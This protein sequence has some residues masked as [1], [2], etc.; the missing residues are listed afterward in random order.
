MKHIALV[1]GLMLLSFA[2]PVSAQTLTD[3]QKADIEKAVK[4]QVAQYFRTVDTM[5]VDAALK[6]WSRE[7]LIAQVASGRVVPSI[8]TMTTNWKNA[9]ANRKTHHFEIQDVMVRV[10][11][12]DTALAI[13][14]GSFRN[15]LKSGNISNYN[16]VA[17]MIWTKDTSGWKVA[18]LGESSVAKQ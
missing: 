4:E 18:Y 13:C 12:P 5:D 8:E 1:I 6:L 3:S 17:T 14:S 11:S 10:F 9:F 2:V 7:K 15:E 16:Y